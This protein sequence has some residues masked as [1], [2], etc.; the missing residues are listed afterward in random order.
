MNH[1]EWCAQW[2]GAPWQGEW[3]DKNTTPAPYFSKDIKL[4][5]KV[6]SAV[7]FVTGLGYFEF[8]VNK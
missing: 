4:E 2:I 7:A 3:E 1:D 5:K 8:Y 6:K